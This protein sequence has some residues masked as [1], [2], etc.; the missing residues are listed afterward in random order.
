LNAYTWLAKSH[1]FVATYSPGL[2][3]LDEDLKEKFL[4]IFVVTFRSIF[5]I[6]ELFA[7]FLSSLAVF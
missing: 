6:T 4:V 3:N 5:T 2:E 1:S 7:G